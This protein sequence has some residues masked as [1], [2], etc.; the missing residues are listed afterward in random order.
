MPNPTLTPPAPGQPGWA[1]ERVA[2]AYTPGLPPVF[3]HG[4]RVEHLLTRHP[5]PVALVSGKFAPLH[6]GHEHLIQRAIESGLPVLVLVYDS[7]GFQPA[8]HVR[9]GW[10]KARFPEV[11]V[12]S[13]FDPPE[14]RE[15]VSPVDEI[16]SVLTQPSHKADLKISSYYARLLREVYSGPV[17]RVY[18]SEAYGTTFAQALGAQHI[19]VDQA[20]AR[21]PVSGTLCRQEPHLARQRGWISPEVYA[22]YLKKVCLVGGESTGKSSLAQALAERLGTVWV[23]E[24]GREFVERHGACQPPDLLHI[25]RVQLQREREALLHPEVNRVLVCDTEAATTLFWSKFY[26]EGWAEPELERLGQDSVGQYMHILCGDEIGFQ[27]DGTRESGH[28]GRD[29]HHAL[30]EHYNRLGAALVPVRGGIEERVEQVLLALRARGWIPE[31]ED[32]LAAP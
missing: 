31:E 16:V 6:T 26:Y 24:Y 28:L 29:Q 5:E 22:H 19:M 32:E 3:A 15:T 4:R 30:I 10:V 18:S 14:H 23:P 20:R 12:L 27:Q 8:V 21:H 25:A 7:P 17:A 9:A 11:R 13:V 1:A 2:P